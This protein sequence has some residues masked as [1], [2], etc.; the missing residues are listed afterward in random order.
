MDMKTFV[1]GA[2]LEY[3]ESLADGQS[4]NKFYELEN[5]GVA[6]HTIPDACMDIQ[7]V[8]EKEVLVPYACGSFLESADSPTG[9]CS[10]CFGIKFNPGRVP[11]CM[12]SI[13]TDLIGNRKRMDEVPWLWEL[14]EKLQMA[15]SFEKKIEVFETEF[16]FEKELVKENS[17]VE[18]AMQRIREENGSLNIAALA[19][20]IGY[21]QKYLDRIFR[22]AT[23]LTMKKYAT[24]IRIQAAI[25]YLLEDKL[26]E[27]Y[28][29]LGYYDQSHFI[30]D[31]K[32]YTC[33]TPSQFSRKKRNAIV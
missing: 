6:F 8:R 9:H 24:I 1:I 4:I 18:F 7:F 2:K 28:E 32:R 26:D 30:K 3:R 19:D 11:D 17:F 15:N 10:Y 16:P 20:E 33:M 13:V 14:G 21:S 31:F 27:V 23:G 25:H 5:P 22:T 29:K 12:R